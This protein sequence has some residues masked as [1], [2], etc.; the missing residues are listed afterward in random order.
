MTKVV[1]A[2]EAR[3]NLGELLNLVHYQGEEILITKSGKTVA[4]ISRPKQAKKRMSKS[5]ADKILQTFRRLSRKGK[6][7]DTTVFIRKERDHGYSNLYR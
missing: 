4:Q 6:K 5:E 3:T 7:I 1:S 2:Y